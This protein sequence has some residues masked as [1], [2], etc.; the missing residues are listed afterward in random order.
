MALESVRLTPLGAKS[1]W[2]G[3]G[4]EEPVVELGLGAQHKLLLA[5]EHCVKPKHSRAVRIKTKDADSVM[6]LAHLRLYATL[7]AGPA[8]VQ[9]DVNDRTPSAD[10]AHLM[11]R[12]SMV[13]SMTSSLS[14]SSLLDVSAVREGRGLR[15]GFVPRPGSFEVWV[16]LHNLELDCKYVSIPVFSRLKSGQWPSQNPHFKQRVEAAIQQLLQRDEEERQYR[17]E[18]NGQPRP[19][20]PREMLTS[21]ARSPWRTSTTLDANIR[22]M[23]RKRAEQKAKAREVEEHKRREEDAAM[24][25]R[26]RERGKG[27]SHIHS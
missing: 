6:E 16:G 22:E 13:S 11:C 4:E 17:D 18:H 15:T 1:A 7:I 19:P 25:A 14:T 27:R 10:H 24:F 9:V 5:V 26:I 3:E 2:V 8:E 21:E 20:T 12:Q 23:Q